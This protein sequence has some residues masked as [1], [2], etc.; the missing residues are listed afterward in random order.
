MG[1]LT[2]LLA[3][4]TWPEWSVVAA[5]ADAS[6][7]A[8]SAALSRKIAVIPRIATAIPRKRARTMRPALESREGPVSVDR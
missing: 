5:A 2:A 4:A 1:R 7:R 6:S 8:S 3:A